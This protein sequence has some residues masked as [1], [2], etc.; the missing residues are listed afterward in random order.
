MLLHLIALTIF[1]EV[2]QSPP[3]RP[4]LHLVTPGLFPLRHQVSHPY[5]RTGKVMLLFAPYCSNSSHCLSLPVQSAELSSRLQR[6]SQS[7]FLQMNTSTVALHGTMFRAASHLSLFGVKWISSTPSNHISL[8]FILIISSHLPFDFQAHSS[9]PDY[10]QEHYNLLDV[11][12]FEMLLNI[13]RKVTA[14]LMT[15]L[16]LSVCLSAAR[17]MFQNS[18]EK[19]NIDE[20]HRK[21]PEKPTA[22]YVCQLKCGCMRLGLWNI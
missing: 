11:P 15:C 6:G 7:E 19:S 5:I 1:C 9:F 16:C 17:R 12:N 13:L 3:L 10:A 2:L 21:W 22:M 18:G 20:N 4:S 8:I 14:A